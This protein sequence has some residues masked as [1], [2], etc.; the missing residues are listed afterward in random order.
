ML[1]TNM[2][3]RGAFTIREAGQVY[4]LRSGDVDRIEQSMSHHQSRA[5][6]TAARNGDYAAAREMFTNAATA[7]YASTPAAPAAA[8]ARPQQRSQRRTTLRY[9]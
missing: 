7:F 6:H 2:Q 9:A 3:G 8:V 1:A 4:H 5:Y